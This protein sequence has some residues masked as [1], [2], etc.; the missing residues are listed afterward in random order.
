MRGLLTAT[1]VSLFTISGLC[2]YTAAASFVR[3]VYKGEEESEITSLVDAHL[4]DIFMGACL[5][6]MEGIRN[7]YQYVNQQEEAVQEV[8]G[9]GVFQQRQVEQQQEHQEHQNVMG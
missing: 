9:A 4:I 7:Q 1:S 3:N 5:G 2:L 6:F 8:V